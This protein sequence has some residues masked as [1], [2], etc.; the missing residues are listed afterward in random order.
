MKKRIALLLFVGGMLFMTG[1]QG[2]NVSTEDDMKEVLASTSESS[3]EE[4]SSDE[5]E[6]VTDEDTASVESE[7]TEVIEEDTFSVNYE[8]YD[9]MA[10][11]L[12]PYGIQFGT[13]INYNSMS[14]DNYLKLIQTHVNSM[15]TGNEMKAYS[16]LDQK[17]SKESADGMPA[18]N[19]KQADEILTFAQ[20]NG[21]GMRGHT[22]VWDAYMTDWFFREGY[23]YNGAYVDQDTM[24]KRLES[25][26]TQVVTHFEENFPGVVY[27]WDVVNEA[28]GDNEKEYQ[29]DD[30]RHIR[31]KRNGNDNP[32]YTLVGSDY[33]ELS[34]LYAKNAVD[35]LKEK[36][37]E[38]DIK[39]IYNDYSTFYNQKRDAIC[40]LVDS[41]NSYHKDGEGNFVKLCDGVGMQSYIG[42][43]GSQ[44]GCMNI[45]DI[46]RIRTAI[47]M[48]AEHDVEVH[49]TE[50]AVRN[51]DNSE[52][53]MK[54][55]ADF[56]QRLFT[57][58]LSINSGESKPLTGISIW[59]IHD[60]PSMSKDDY[61]YKMN[62]PYCG[63]FTENYEVKKSFVN[64]YDMLKN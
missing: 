8:D 38:V 56:Y 22:L 17:A 33:V 50:M 53:T 49:V 54:S 15:T 32:F 24:K 26:I 40:Q 64:I 52:Q 16:M 29:A 11:L 19:Y 58:Y 10:E 27:C 47:E 20:E 46:T 36:N 45:S 14:N 59:G 31:T 12:E 4:E 3:N 1:C 9:S 61:S 35:A 62:G 23:D 44:S 39:L 57:M 5:E 37:P 43:Y 30:A 55:H 25:Y 34:F 63:L 2:K 48:F 41:I 13:V 21:I 6:T 7:E 51:Y 42:G 18:M 60:R 28:V